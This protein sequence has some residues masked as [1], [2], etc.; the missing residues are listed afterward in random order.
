M[1][2]LYGIKP[3]GLRRISFA[4]DGFCI[5]ARLATMSDRAVFFD[6][7]HRRWWW[8]KR[9]GTLLGLFAVVTISAWLVS[10]FTAPLLPGMRGI[11]I[12]IIRSIRRSTH[13]PRPQ[14]RAQQFLLKRDR[15]KLLAAI[16]QDKL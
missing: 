13:F 2:A 3:L 9:L 7:T 14:S 4:S 8:V 15:G 6:P 1:A 12:P 5:I 10:L 16:T 11:T